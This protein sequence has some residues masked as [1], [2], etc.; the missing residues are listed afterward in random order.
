MIYPALVQ[1]DEAKNSI[2]KMIE[3]ANRDAIAEVLIVGR[4]GGSIEDL[5]A[6]NEE[7]VARAVYNSKIPIV[8]AVGH[9][10]DFTII[11]FVSDLRAPTPSGAAELVVPD[12]IK[13]KADLVKLRQKMDLLETTRLITATK[14]F[15]TLLRSTV[16]QNPQ[17]IFEKSTLQ[18]MNASSRLEQ[19]SPEKTLIKNQEKVQ[20]LSLLLQQ[21]FRLIF[22][23]KTHSF[24]SMAEK[25]ELLNPLSI[26]KK[27]YSVLKKGSK[28][29]RSI[30]EFQIGDT[31]GMTL[32]DGSASA[33]VQSIRKEE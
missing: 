17:R 28:I 18:L 13:L 15:K 7:I 19:C 20:T 24:I 3:K 27:G 29:I 5:W 16:F 21:N 10:T 11:D 26:M 6:F 8:S 32:S 2:V 9:E 12:Q 23:N 31:V 1:G 22:E 25:L 33:I 14:S 4:G 30:Q